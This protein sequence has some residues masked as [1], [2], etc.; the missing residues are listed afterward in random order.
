MVATKKILTV[1]AFPT[2]VLGVLALAPSP[3]RERVSIAG[4]FTMAYVKREMVQIPDAPGHLL[5]VAEARGSNRNTGPSD[6]MSGAQA[7]ALETLD[8]VQGSGSTQ[9]YVVQAKD[10]DSVFVGIKGRV[11]TTMS[12]QGSPSTTFEGNWVFLRGTG[13]YRGIKG[14]G[15]FRGRF[16]SQTEYT[17]DWKGEYSR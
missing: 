13:Q 11:T 8:L 7:S 12:P 15:T 2:T 16:T 10:A 3:A 1:V 9:G 17:V 6:F 4:T 5:I 14:S